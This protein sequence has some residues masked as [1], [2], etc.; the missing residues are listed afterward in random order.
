MA[1]HQEERIM[2]R[3][4]KFFLG[5]LAILAV[6]LFQDPSSEKLKGRGE[7]LVEEVAR[8][9]ECHTPQTTPGH[10]NRSQWL[11]GAPIW[12]EPIQKPFDWA[13]RAPRIAGLPSFPDETA[14]H[15]LENSLGPNGYAPRLP[16][17]SYHLPRADAD[18][19]ISYLRSMKAE[20]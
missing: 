5:F 4:K 13:Y 9:W 2:I 12:F 8:C 3:D 20:P 11:Q 18:A 10:W 6:P 14:R 7:Y 19:I 16:M 17:H 1:E 15:I